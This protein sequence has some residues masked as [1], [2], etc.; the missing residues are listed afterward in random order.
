MFGELISKVFSSRLIVQA[1]L[2]LL[3]VST[4]PVETYVKCFGVITAH[5]AGEDAVGGRAVGFDWGRRLRVANFHEGY[6]DGNILLAVE[7]NRSSFGF[8]GGIHEGAYGFTFGEYRS[9][10]GRSGTDVGRW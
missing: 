10:R 6:A 4:H 1:E 8:H 2:I 5:V 7:E 9:I 3:D